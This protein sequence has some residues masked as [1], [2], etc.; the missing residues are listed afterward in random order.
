MKI[1]AKITVTFPSA[2]RPLQKMAMFSNVVVETPRG[3]RAKSRM[4]RQG[5]FEGVAAS[6]GGCHGH[7]SDPGY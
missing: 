2:Y 1:F 3:S 5:K 4:I 7:Y 6:K